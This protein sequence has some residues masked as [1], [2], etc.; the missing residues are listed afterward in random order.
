MFR[1]DFTSY[2]TAL[3]ALRFVMYWT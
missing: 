3:V 2:V 1:L